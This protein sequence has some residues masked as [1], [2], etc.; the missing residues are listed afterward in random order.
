MLVEIA[1]EKTK[2]PHVQLNSNLNYVTF[3]FL[4]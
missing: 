2:N 1:T 4:I 3:F